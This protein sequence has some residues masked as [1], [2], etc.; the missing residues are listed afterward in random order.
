MPNTKH[1]ILTSSRDNNIMTCFLPHFSPQRII[2]PNTSCQ[3]KFRLPDG[4][5]IISSPS[6]GLAISEMEF[7]SSHILLTGCHVR[8]GSTGVF[9]VHYRLLTVTRDLAL[10]DVTPDYRCRIGKIT[11]TTKYYT[12]ANNSKNG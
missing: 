8:H 3:L 4:A 9:L 12:L 11:Y 10:V 1:M 6:A 2:L 7:I 5:I